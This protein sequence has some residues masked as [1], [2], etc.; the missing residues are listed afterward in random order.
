MKTF[1]EWQQQ[2]FVAKWKAPDFE[3]EKWEL[4]GRGV[5]LMHRGEFS[6][7]IDPNL[8]SEPTQYAQEFYNELITYPEFVSVAKTQSKSATCLAGQAFQI[9][10]RMGKQTKGNWSFIFKSSPDDIN[11]SEVYQLINQIPVSQTEERIAVANKWSNNTA[12]TGQERDLTSIA[13]AIT[14]GDVFPS[15]MIYQGKAIAF[16]GGKTRVFACMALNIIPDIWIFTK[17][18]V[19]QAVQQLNNQQPVPSNPNPAV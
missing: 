17:N 3:Y 8:Q 10:A 11:F 4:F 9:A 14:S 1:N 15:P 16:V 7:I 13:K 18:N 2:N 19:A 5:E 6:D 12:S